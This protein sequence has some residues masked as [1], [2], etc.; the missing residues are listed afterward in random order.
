LTPSHGCLDHQLCPNRATDNKHYYKFKLFAGLF[1]HI[2]TTDERTLSL[3]RK[4]CPYSK[5]IN[6]LKF[7]AQPILHNP[8]RTENY[9]YEGD[10]FFAG[11]WYHFPQRV[12]E[13]TEL[14]QLPLSI[15][16]HIYER[17]FKGNNSKFPRMFQ[18]RIKKGISYIEISEKYKKY[19]I[20]LNVNSVKGSTTM[21]SRRVPEAL[22]CGVTVISSPS[23]S[24]SKLFPHVFISYSKEHLSS[25]IKYL[26]QNSDFRNEHNHNGRREILQNH[27][28]YT[29]MMKI[30]KIINIKPPVYRNGVVNL[31]VTSDN[32]TH[33]NLL[34][35]DIQ[36]QTYENVV[37]N[38]EVTNSHLIINILKNLF[39]HRK[40]PDGTINETIGYVCLFNTKSRYESN[41]ILDS[42]LTYSY[43]KDIDVIGKACFNI[44]ENSKIN[45][46]YPELENRY[47]DL[48]HPHTVTISL[49]GDIEKKEKKLK[50][51]RNILGDKNVAKENLKIY[52][53]DRYNFVF[54][55]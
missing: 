32:I 27:T 50:Y 31:Y 35:S 36:K 22:L 39:F 26:L 20:M 15:K 55:K 30:C 37:C 8:V 12:R 23:I 47:T 21:F 2:F 44:W 43:F 3:Y 5:S 13:L 19:P 33:N 53:S 9:K 52:S 17:G 54:V 42:I 40:L 24:I 48:I 38:I 29:R 18:K 1:D 6:V 41:Y 51:L 16:L 34:I 10:V 14:L 28:Y 7:A 4:D 25:T 46:L 11:G 45:I 49:F